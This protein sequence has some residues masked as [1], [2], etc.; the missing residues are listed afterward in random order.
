MKGSQGYFFYAVGDTRTLENILKNILKRLFFSARAA[1]EHDEPML[2]RNRDSPAQQLVYLVNIVIGKAVTAFENSVDVLT[3]S[4]YSC[5]RFK[6]R[7][8]VAYGK[9]VGAHRLFI[10]TDLFV[11]RRRKIIRVYSEYPV[12][13]L[14]CCGKFPIQDKAPCIAV[15][16]FLGIGIGFVILL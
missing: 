15:Y 12:I 9:R 14:S 16:Y 7:Q 8:V 10:S 3:Y 1:E 4:G 2:V 13:K 11:A 6:N 5:Y